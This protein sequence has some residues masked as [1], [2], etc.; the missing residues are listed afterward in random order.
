MSSP[1]KPFNEI[2]GTR[3]VGE[4]PIDQATFFRDSSFSPTRI[5]SKFKSISPLE[6]SLPLNWTPG[7]TRRSR[8]SPSRSHHQ[9]TTVK[10]SIRLKKKFFG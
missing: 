5:E 9:F 1:M 10:G 3:R 6:F 2:R 8:V 4:T 7:K